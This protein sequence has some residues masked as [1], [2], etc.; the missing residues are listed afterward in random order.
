[1]S[2]MPPPLVCTVHA[3]AMPFTVTVA[4]GVGDGSGG[5]PGGADAAW[6]A[7][8]EAAIADFHAQLLWADDVFSLWSE[9]SVLARWLRGEVEAEDTPP[10]VLEVLQACEWYR[11]AT[12]G[13]FDARGP[14]GLDPTGLVKGWAVWRAS[15][16]FADLPGAWMVD[17]AGDVLVGGEHVWEVGIAHP[18]TRGVPRPSHLVDV[19]TLGGSGMRALATSGV[20]Q[21]G[22]H[23][24]D[25]ATGEPAA[26][27]VQASVAGPDLVTADVW[28]TAV[29]AAGDG[30]VAGALAAGCEVLVVRGVRED[31]VD[32]AASAGWPRS[33]QAAGR[34]DGA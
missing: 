13:A 11:G 18:D 20:G 16:P 12:A 1:M 27:V 14:R 10:E 25:P 23:I 32:A 4:R 33:D 17:A 24:W 6:E 19:V 3:M 22:A 31:G 26:H 8:W 5:G 30:A 9:D 15:R 28:A 7:A 21:R 2:D 29:V 34:A